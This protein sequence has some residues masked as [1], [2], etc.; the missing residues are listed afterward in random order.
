MS[1]LVL[2]ILVALCTAG[3]PRAVVGAESP[4]PPT[5]AAAAAQHDDD[6]NPLEPARPRSAAAAP[7]PDGK[8]SPLTS[9]KWVTVLGAGAAAGTG[10]VMLQQARN[11]ASLLEAARAPAGTRPTTPYDQT[12]RD[13]E[14]DY[15]RM[16]TWAAAAFIAGGAL[17]AAA[18]TLFLLDQESEAPGLQARLAP[19]VGRRSTGL[20]LQGTF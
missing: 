18:V 12:I 4:A 19:L 11:E 5:V 20:G 3:G 17:T 2:P 6:E 13:A 15:V 8:A 1:R 7:E 16:R 10:L 9:W 14:R